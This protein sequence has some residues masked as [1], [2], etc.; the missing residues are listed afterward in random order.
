MTAKDGVCEICG[1]ND[2]GAGVGCLPGIPMSVYM[3]KICATVGA[4]PEW[5]RENNEIS[6]YFDKEIDCYQNPSDGRSIQFTYKDGTQLLTRKEISKKE[7][8][9]G[10]NASKI[11]DACKFRMPFGKH[12]GKRLDDLPKS[13]LQWAAENISDSEVQEKADIVLQWMNKYGIR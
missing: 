5:A 8:T 10:D 7:K 6:P 12:H 9:M 1:Y 2:L 3:C 13:Y 11:E 4:I